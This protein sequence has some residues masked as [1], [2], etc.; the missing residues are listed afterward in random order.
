MTTFY[1]HRQAMYNAL[2]RTG[3]GAGV[4]NAVPP[5]LEEQPTSNIEFVGVQNF[6]NLYDTPPELAAALDDIAEEDDIAELDHLGEQ[7]ERKVE[8][9]ENIKS[10]IQIN[11][12][13]SRIDVEDV[14]QL[15]TG[16]EAYL[17]GY[18]FKRYELSQAIEA[19][20]AT[21]AGLIA[22]G[23]AA[24][25]ALIYKLFKWFT[26]RSSKGSSV[27]SAT[28]KKVE[29]VTEKFNKL[30]ET[31]EAFDLSKIVSGEEVANQLKGL[32]NVEKYK[33]EKHVKMETVIKAVSAHLMDSSADMTCKEAGFIV[34]A[35]KA[36]KLTTYVKL[37][38]VTKPQYDRIIS[39]VKLL[40]SQI[41]LLLGK[42]TDANAKI[43]RTLEDQYKEIH[44]IAKNVEDN[45][46]TAKQIFE[47]VTAS[48]ATISIEDIKNAA[49]AL[50]E[51]D[52]FA[53]DETIKTLHNTMNE[54]DAIGNSKDTPNDLGDEDKKLLKKYREEFKRVQ[55]I[56]MMVA[57]LQAT[58]QKGYSYLTKFYEGVTN[59]C[60]SA[61]SASEISQS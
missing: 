54:L 46:K 52:W 11:A 8:Q 34:Q 4:E 21:Q 17:P 51:L 5:E 2:T 1:E 27:N 15:H 41:E 50:K 44:L 7:N 59:L 9:L 13:G 39:Y 49:N 56:L 42:S 31:P 14:V 43:D 16:A 12:N 61:K 26:N 10:A 28:D 22:A 47:A 60:G 36:N 53:D 37:V 33:Q 45:S 55:A 23:I 58:L 25:G 29:E 35:N 24:L 38:T 19:I 57:G 30:A 20:N 40:H 6:E 32:P 3:F 18:R 48:N